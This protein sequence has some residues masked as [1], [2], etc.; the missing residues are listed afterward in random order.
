MWTLQDDTR[1][2]AGY[3]RILKDGERVADV[4]PFASGCD[5][6]WVTAQ[7]HRIVEQ[8]NSVDMIRAQKAQG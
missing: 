2:N 5:R 8:M 1:T 6:V 7:A 3:I 4:F